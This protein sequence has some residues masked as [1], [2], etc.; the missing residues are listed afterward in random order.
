MS[1]I[2]STD[3]ELAIIRSKLE[4]A[5][6]QLAEKDQEITHLKEELARLHQGNSPT[7]VTQLISTESSIVYFVCNGNGYKQTVAELQS[8]WLTICTAGMSI[9]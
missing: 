9:P 8:L 4:K 2:Q 1:Q 3:D 7:N 6:D 5:L